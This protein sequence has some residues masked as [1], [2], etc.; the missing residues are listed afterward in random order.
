M[1]WYNRYKIAAGEQP[2][3]WGGFNRSLLGTL[4]FL[5]SVMALTLYFGMPRPEAEKAVRQNPQQVE[6][7]L[8]KIPQQII[9]QA[10]Q[11]AQQQPSQPLPPTAQQQPQTQQATPYSLIS[12]ASV[13][14][15]IQQHEGREAVAYGD[16]T[17][18]MTVGVGFNLQRSDARTLLS[19]VGANYDKVLAQEQALTDDQIDRLYEI[20]LNEAFQTAQRFIPNL[21]THPPQVQKVV[22]DMAFNLGPQRL[23]GFRNFQS[24]INRRDYNTAANEMTNS[25]W[26]GQVRNRGPELVNLMRQGALQY[27]QT[28]RS[29]GQGTSPASQR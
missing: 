25:T 24:A 27:A 28:I 17:G 12:P 5:G 18:V 9:Q 1:D 29:Q 20:T 26:F 21:G 19:Q 3:Q 10:V 8:Q 2:F 7:S 4:G 23:G 16:T 13:R 6:Q 11:M 15:Q 14:D 22:V